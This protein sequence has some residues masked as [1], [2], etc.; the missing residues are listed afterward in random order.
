MPTYIKELPTQE[1]LNEHF[2]T[3]EGFVYWKAKIISRGRKSEREGRRIGTYIDG[4]GYYRVGIGKQSYPLSRVV[5][6]MVYGGL[7]PDYE[8][9]H[10]DKDRLNNLPSNLRK[11]RQGINKRNKGRQKNAASDATGVCLCKKRHPKPHNHKITEYWVARWYDLDG[12][13]VGK[14][15]NISKLGYDEAFR[16][17]CE[18]R[19]KMIAELN[20]QG[21]G[22][23]DE[24]GR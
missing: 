8:V 15:F 18:Y 20:E 11:V 2:Y 14:N 16:A 21:A 7:T 9:D 12:R 23:T 5:Y 10:K 19:D 24:H 4:E 6:Q 3:E 1:W 22:Y 17:A 13:L